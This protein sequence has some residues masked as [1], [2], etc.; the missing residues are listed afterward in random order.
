MNKGIRITFMTI[1]CL[2]AT[3]VTQAQV[4]SLTVTVDGLACPFCAYG[5]EKKL[6][7]AVP[8]PATWKCGSSIDSGGTISQGSRMLPLLLSAQSCPPVMTIRNW[9]IKGGVQLPLYHDLHGDQ[10]EE[11]YRFKL[12][13]ELHY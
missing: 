10:P 13:I 4:E 8:A 9:A 6:K 5:I 2:M 12:A 7:K 3:A 1:I 11:D